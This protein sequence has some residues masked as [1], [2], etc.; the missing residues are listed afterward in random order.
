LAV[1]EIYVTPSLSACSLKNKDVY[2]VVKTP[3]TQA[4]DFMKNPT[5]LRIENIPGVPAFNYQLT[6]NLV[7]NSS[8]TVK[9][10]TGVTITKGTHDIKAYISPAID[11]NLL[12]DTARLSLNINPALTITAQPISIASCLLRGDDVSQDVTITNTGNMDISDMT[13]TFEVSTQSQG[14][15]H[16]DIAKRK[17]TLS[18]G[19]SEKLAF[20]YIVPASAMYDVNIGVTMD[21]DPLLL[22]NNQ[23]GFRE[24]VETEDLALYFI[25]PLAQKS[26]EVDSISKTKDLEVSVKNEG[27]T[28]NYTDITIRTHIED[29]NGNVL[30]GP[31]VDQITDYIYPLD[32]FIYIRKYTVPDVDY[33]VIKVFI[34]NMDKYPG[35]DTIIT[36][37][38]RKTNKVNALSTIVSDVFTLGQNIPN[39]AKDN[40]MI[41]YSI[42]LSGEVVFKVQSVSGQILYTQTLQS[43]SGK[44]VIELKT[45]DLA[46]GIYFYSM[47]YKGQKLVKRMSIKK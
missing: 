8:D 10:T 20:P 25:K 39:P 43:E 4:I 17:I 3:T 15:V 7:G 32:S 42:P 16:T 31:F 36:T 9:V 27:S 11:K 18:S 22:N 2:V 23:I 6:K 5:Y 19:Q 28:Q 45:S 33:Y 44:H 14:T 47:E 24:C 1:S 13:V 38:A 37:P 46:A 35:T 41:E 21:C 29:L 26:G 34:D 40:T 12:N 30:S